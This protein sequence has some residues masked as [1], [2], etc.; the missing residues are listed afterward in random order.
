MNILESI[1]KTFISLGGQYHDRLNVNKGIT[2]YL[3]RDEALNSLRKFD[4]K[5]FGKRDLELYL[6]DLNFPIIAIPI[7]A[8]D[9]S[10]PSIEYKE[11]LF[12]S[13]SCREKIKAIAKEYRVPIHSTKK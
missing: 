8:Y 1:F 4:E 13:D 2:F 11:W 10:V 5:M 3:N 6:N 7:I 9:A 12:D